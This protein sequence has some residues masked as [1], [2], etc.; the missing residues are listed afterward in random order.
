[1]KFC[2]ITTFFGP[3][4]F[5]GDAAYVDRLCQALCR[6]G[7]EVHVF[8]CV[9]AFN[10][11]RGDH[12]L[13]SYTPTPGLHLHPLESGYGT[14]SPLATQATGL[15]LFKSKALREVLDADDLDVVHFHNISLVGGP[16]VLGLGA[17]TRAVRIMTAHEHWLICPMHLLW[18]YDRKPCDGASCLRCTVAGGR[19]P[20]AWRYTN[21]IPKALGHLDALLFPSAHALEE[22]RSRGVDRWAP[23]VHLPYFLPDDWSQGIEDEEPT[24]TERPYL[25]AAGRLVAMKGFQRLIPL[26]RNLPEADL[27][28]AGT[29]PYEASLRKLAEGLPNVHFEGLLGGQGLARLFRGSRAVVVPSLFPETFG[30][31]V[32]EAFATGTPVIVHEGGG[33]ILETGV[34]S[35]GGLGYRTDTELLTAMRRMVHDEDLRSGL[36]AQG[37]SQ[38]IGPWSETEHVH[39]YLEL[40]AGRR[41]AR[42]SGVKTRL[43]PAAGSLAARHATRATSSSPATKAR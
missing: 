20:Q 29:G 14:L 16:G 32:L 11:V 43:D 24:P 18:K 22:H 27:R 17:N 40:I 30:Y 39:R 3:H 42:D 21:A 1:M 15:P 38:R 25:A 12:P 4:S 13:R 7:H 23:L 41:A 31:V 8:Y 5:G 6:R 37:F 34:A 2:M 10:A 35:G 33:A 36:A 26:M 19:P 28:I 9:D